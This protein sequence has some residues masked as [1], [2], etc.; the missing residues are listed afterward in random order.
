MKIIGKLFTVISI[1]VLLLL[2]GSAPA[3]AD[4][5]NP[6]TPICTIT[7]NNVI[8]PVDENAAPLVPTSGKTDNDASWPVTIKFNKAAQD[9]LDI[10]KGDKGD[11]IPILAG[12]F[13]QWYG[14]ESYPLIKNGDLYGLDLHRPISN[15]PSGYTEPWDIEVDPNHHG[16][17]D[18][19]KPLCRRVYVKL[20]WT[21]T[22][23]STVDC[24]KEMETV[25]AVFND[26]KNQ[27][28]NGIP[29]TVSVNLTPNLKAGCNANAIVYTVTKLNSDINIPYQLNNYSED[30]PL[31]ISYTPKTVGQ[32][33]VTLRAVRYSSCGGNTNNPILNCNL[34]DVTPP[35]VKNFCVYASGGSGS[36]TPEVPP[37]PS[38][39]AASTVAF[40]LCRQI[41]IPKTG[42]NARIERLLKEKTQCCACA[43]GKLGGD[44]CEPDNT[45]PHKA[46]GIYTAVGCI[47]T[48]TN[49]IVGSFI[50]LGLGIAGGVALL[51]I[52]AG[53]FMYTTS[54][55]E[56]KR[57][58]EAKE[59]ITSAVMGLLFI[60][61]S[62]T[63]LQ[64]IGV[65]ILKIPGFGD[66]PPGSAAAA[67]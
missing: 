43:G 66:S 57:A 19:S 30:G 16:Q 18:E 32:Y 39:V 28:E 64:F 6:L 8:L 25:K 65:S 26:S 51:M 48:D 67:K 10:C 22:K 31:N 17:C 13:G 38:E 53:G 44:E 1:L 63:I 21:K 33:S 47:G 35:L 7:V 37:P 61:F 12:Q 56:P 5:D 27:I 50:K 3:Y 62:V 14:W 60:I 24:D 29:W 23:S 46:T 9:A 54:Q 15:T 4:N 36:C 11:A 52:L 45:D 59:L 2:G 55:G 34:D 40:D 20:D 58:G 41:S 42:S 49:S